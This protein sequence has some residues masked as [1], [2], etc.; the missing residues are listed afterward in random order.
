MG[1]II[2][3]PNMKNPSHHASLNDG[4]NKYGLKLMK[5]VR[6]FK[7][8]PLVSNTLYFSGQ[9][10]QYGDGEPG[11]AQVEQRNWIGGRGTVDFSEESSNFFDSYQLFTA[12]NKKIFPTL[13]WKMGSGIKETYGNLPGN[14]NWQPIVG[15]ESSDIRYFS[16]KFTVGDSAYTPDKLYLWAKLHGANE[17]FFVAIYTDSGGEP[18]VIKGT[19]TTVLSTNFERDISKY[20]EI[21]ISGA[22]E[23][24]LDTDYHIVIL[25]VGDRSNYWSFGMD[26]DAETTTSYLSVGSPV[27]WEDAEGNLYFRLTDELD[28]YPKVFFEFRG[29][30]YAV[31]KP[32]NGT[33]SKLYIN[34]YRGKA[35]AGDTGSLTDT[36]QAWGADTLI[37]NRI[38]IIGGTGE[39]QNA[40]IYSNIGTIIEFNDMEIALDN[41]SLY[42]IYKTDEWTDI[43]PGSGALFD[44]PITDVKNI[45]DFVY[46]AR[47]SEEVVLRMRWNEGGTPPV[48]EFENDTANYAH[49]IHTF[50]DD[51]AD[52]PQV[53]YAYNAAATRSL[54]RMDLPGWATASTSAKTMTVGS[55]ASKITNM[56]DYNSILYMLKE[57]GLYYRDY[58]GTNERIFREK[59]NIDFIKHTNTGEALALDNFFLVFSWAGFSIEKVQKIDSTVA[60]N[61]IGV[62]NNREGLPEDRNGPVTHLVRHP[63]G[64]IAC[65]DAG[66]DGYSAI[67]IH[68]EPASWHEVFRSPVRGM[69]IKSFGFQDMPGSFLRLWID[70]GDDIAYQDWSAGGLKPIYSSGVTFQHEGHLLTSTYDMGAF[71]MQKYF[72][73]LALVTENL[74]AG[75]SIEIDYQVDE[76]VG[77]DEWQYLSGMHESPESEIEI[78]EGNRKQI[79]FRFRLLTN[80]ASIP[81]IVNASV[82]D[83]FGRVPFKEQAVMYAKA[84]DVSRD[85]RGSVDAPTDELYSWLKEKAEQAEGLKME[86]I[87]PQWH[88]KTV[89]IQP[90]QITRSFKNMILNQEGS[91]VMISVREA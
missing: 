57:D 13:Q 53:Y 21:D 78:R 85:R 9:N 77:S 34:G 59:L 43:S 32:L 20:V 55:K 19:G 42:V 52:D 27:S 29:G 89:L 26:S 51:I 87:I 72:H 2:V 14:M 24:T 64:L 83:M 39:G 56:T 47:G 3:A 12:H 22:G 6:G 36:N 70:L 17:S 25:N 30:Y 8:G 75:V 49:V 71:R 88:G 63:S 73:K 65:V 40:L 35:T 48:H 11:L 41:T 80:D 86:S 33:T 61:D 66:D 76:N 68:L 54:D 67:Y 62:Q 1:K 50:S 45:G 4:V 79:R 7:Q 5:G 74:Q 18:N 16:A 31:T 81:P 46:F 15:E 58:D 37:G 44:C 84:S 82:I 38:K 60:A 91:I 23:L 10:P 69:R 90:P 28:P